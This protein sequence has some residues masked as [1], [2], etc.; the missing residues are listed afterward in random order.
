VTQ[1]AVPDNEGRVRLDQLE[2]VRAVC[3]AGHGDVVVFGRV[4]WNMQERLYAC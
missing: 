3:W 4:M 1:I 2:V